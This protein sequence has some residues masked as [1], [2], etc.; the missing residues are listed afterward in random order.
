MSH[1]IK[2][3]MVNFINTAPLYEVWKERRQTSPQSL[4]QVLEA[5]PSKLNRLLMASKLDM[6]FISSHEYAQRPGEYRILSDLSISANGQV[7][8]VF[9][10]SQLSIAELDGKVVCLSPLSQT[11][12]SLI[13]IILEDF[14]HI[15]PVYSLESEL[16][17]PASAVLAIGDNALRLHQKGDYRQVLD[18]SMVWQKYTQLPFVFAVWAVREDSLQ[19]YPQEV[20]AIHQELKHCVDE[21]SR[22]LAEI[23][24][25]V[26]PRIPMAAADCFEYLQKI[27]Y[28]LNPAKICGLEKF[29]EYLMRRGEADKKAL[30]LKIV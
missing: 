28:D 8:S 21:G 19:K 12:N 2:I 1:K 11:S 24:A 14:Y 6:G 25:S 27:E 30:P 15:K 3:G 22:R 5:P 20:D 23:S 17:R 4:W 7:G 29:Y 18:L 26:A 13:K 9:L 10:F 16:D